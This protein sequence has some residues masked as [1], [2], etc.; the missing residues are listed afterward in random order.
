MSSSPL[1]ASRPISSAVMSA[2]RPA[3]DGLLGGGAAQR[4]RAEAEQSDSAAGHPVVVVEF[5]RDG[6]AG[7]GEIAVPPGELLDREAATA[8]TTRGTARPSGSR[9]A[10][11]EVSHRPVKNSAAG[12]SRAPPRTTS[13]PSSRPARAPPRRTPRPDRRARSRL[14][15]CRGYGSGSGRCTASTAS[16]AEPIRPPRRPCRPARAAFPRRSTPGRRAARCSAA[17]RPGRCRRGCSKCVSRIASIGTRLCPPARIFASS[18]YS[19]S[20]ST[21]SSTVSGRW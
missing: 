12:I 5:D 16:A 9:R 20:S 21:A 11:N 15:A 6:G 10:A 3:D 14:R 8:R 18:P 2:D 17:R 7:D 19:P 1:I 4:R 13:P